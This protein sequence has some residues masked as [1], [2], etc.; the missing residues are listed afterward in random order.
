MNLHRKLQPPI[1]TLKNKYIEILRTP[2]I[3]VESENSE[4]QIFENSN[5]YFDNWS[6]VKN[7]NIYKN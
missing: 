4:S 2:K 6:F 7:N 1:P 3:F 5:K